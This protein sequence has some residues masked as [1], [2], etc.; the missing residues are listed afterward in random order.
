MIL[1]TTWPKKTSWPVHNHHFSPAFLARW[2]QSKGQEWWAAALATTPDMAVAL[3]CAIW[4]WQLLLSIWISS[5]CRWCV[6]TFGKKLYL[7]LICPKKEWTFCK[8]QVVL[9]H[10][11]LS[12]QIY[13]PCWIH[14]YSSG[15]EVTGSSC[16]SIGGFTHSTRKHPKT[17][18]GI[19][20]SLF[21]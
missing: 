9:T 17:R 16:R 6:L 14:V 12:F 11:Y 5:G 4:P 7:I 13:S 8:Y 21:E 2:V 20:I 19:I 15:S 3:W 10:A 1:K 18:V